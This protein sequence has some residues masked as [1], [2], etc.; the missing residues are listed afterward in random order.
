MFYPCVAANYHGRDDK[1]RSL[2]MGPIIPQ[3]LTQRTFDF[4]ALT[5]QPVDEIV[6]HVNLAPPQKQ[7]YCHQCKKWLPATAEYW[8]RARNTADGLSSPCKRNKYVA[9]HPHPCI[10]CNIR[11]AVNDHL[12]G[13][14]V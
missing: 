6:P 14:N 4:D 5:D 7:K 11:S 8:H 13:A 9:D 10:R 1:N 12:C 3:N 2:A